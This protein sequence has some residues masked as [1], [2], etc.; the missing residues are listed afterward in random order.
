MLTSTLRGFQT[1]RTLAVAATVL[2]L[3]GCD[4]LDP[5]NVNNPSTTTDDLSAAEN[6]TAALLPGL[7]AAFATAYNPVEPEVV[8][9]NYSIH[10]TGLVKQL[11]SPRDVTPDEIGNRAYGNLQTLRSLADF[12]LTDIA[13]NDTTALP[14][15]LQEARYYLGMAFLILGE[16]FGGAPVVADGTPVASAELVRTAIT[17]LNAALTATTGGGFEVQ[18]R[19]ALARAYRLDGNAGE[20]ETQAD[21]VLAAD[22]AF[23]QAQEYDPATI[24]NGPFAFLV[25][26]SLKEM[27][28]LPRLDFLDP[29][30]TARDAPI[31]VAKAEEMLLIKAEVE[32]SR[33]NYAG[34]REFIAQA[35][36]SAQARSTSNFNDDDARLNED[37]SERPHDASITIRSDA[38]SP[39]RAGL[40]LSRPG[41]VSTPTVAA[42]SLDADSVRALDAT[43][44]TEDIL[45]AF[46][47]ARQ[48]MML[49]E[50][51]RMTDLGIRLPVERDEIETNA[52]IND[53]DLGTVAIVPAYIPA[54]D[55]MDL[56]DPASPYDATGMLVTT[57]I[58]IN[59]DMNR[60]LAQQRISPFGTRRVVVNLPTENIGSTIPP[61]TTFPATYSPT[62]GPSLN[63]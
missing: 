18:I 61:C 21:A 58:T 45:H 51:R 43:T 35:I 25:I 32:F 4:F 23:S 16:R 34:G 7:R 46:H 56:F 2:T 41:P 26:R 19:A 8:S 3:V 22:P 40:V 36:E 31:Y 13:P 30:Y 29:K 50:G 24:T 44:Q 27:Q 48:E 55:L 20:A 42:T 12:V 49:L 14:D 53:G 38:S 57:Q 17:E 63:A 1:A 9:D 37:L 5:T 60:I 52:N 10:G 33:G 47:L 28:P 11:D 6:P 62:D 15:D 39:F 59:V 54:Q